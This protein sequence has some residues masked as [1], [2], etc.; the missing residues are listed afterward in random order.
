MS[1]GSQYCNA[2]EKKA[3]R[4][5]FLLLLFLQGVFYP[6]IS[7]TTFK[8]FIH[9]GISTNL[10]MFL[11]LLSVVVTVLFVNAVAV[12]STSPLVNNDFG[13]VSERLFQKQRI[14]WR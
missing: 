2:R 14:K 12:A 5:R 4:K 9:C 1:L 13:P 8:H 3:K 6:S 10:F 7:V 11:C